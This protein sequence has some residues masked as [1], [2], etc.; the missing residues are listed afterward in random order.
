MRMIK[1]HTTKLAVAAAA[2]AALTATTAGSA[3]MF[4]DRL[5]I[6]TYY[7][8]ASKTQVVGWAQEF[9]YGDMA[10]LGQATGTATAYYD[11]EV[12][13]RCPFGYY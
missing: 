11:A 2:L 4:G 1:T 7:S 12:V 13:G 8:D 10:L 9:C 6:Y 3:N 5:H